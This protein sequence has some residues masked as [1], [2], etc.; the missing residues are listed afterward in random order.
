MGGQYK[1]WPLFIWDSRLLINILSGGHLFLAEILSKY[2][3]VHFFS[4]TQLMGGI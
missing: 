4:Y 3:E 2:I 1:Q